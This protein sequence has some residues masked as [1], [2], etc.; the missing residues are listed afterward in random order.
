MENV[1]YEDVTALFNQASQDIKSGDMLF[2]PNF[3]LYDSMSAIEIYDA[4]MD[5]KANLKDVVGCHE[6]IKSNS[7]KA[8]QD[9]SV[10]ELIG[11]FDDLLGKEILWLSGQS[12]SHTIFTFSYLYEPQV[13]EGHKYLQPY[14][15][16]LYSGSNLCQDLIRHS[17]YL[18]EEDYIASSVGF[19]PTKEYEAIAQ[20]LV[21]IE[22][23]L[24]KQ[25]STQKKK[26]KTQQ[27]ENKAVHN[28]F[29][30]LHARIKLRRTLLVLYVNLKTKFNPKVRDQVQNTINSCFKT[31]EIVKQSLEHSENCE[32]YFSDSINKT[33]LAHIPPRQ[34]KTISKADAFKE[35]ENMLN[36]IQTILRLSDLQDFYEI[37][38]S[39]QTFSLTPK[40]VLVRAYLDVNVFQKDEYFGLI[41]IKNLALSAI[42]DFNLAKGRDIVSRDE[43]VKFV[44]KSVGILE[45]I[46]SNNLRNRTKQK[47]E[48]CK[49]YHSINVLAHDAYTLDGALF[50]KKDERNH[51]L[52]LW[53]MDIG[54]KFMV[55]QL[56]QGFELN[57]YADEEYCIIFYLLDNTISY[58]ERNFR[59][60]ISKYDNREFLAA[61]QT[62]D[63]TYDKKKKKLSPFQRRFFFESQYFK[64]IENYVSAM[65][66]LSYLIVYKEILKI[67]QDPEFLKNRY[68]M[69]LRIFDNVYFLRKTEFEDFAE[70]MKRLEEVDIETTIKECKALFESNVKLLNDIA[71]EESF[72][73]RTR[74]ELDKLKRICVMNSLALTTLDRNKDNLTNLKATF[75]NN[76]HPNYPILTLQKKA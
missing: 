61:W 76:E 52:F 22:R 23:E 34:V 51:V 21:E 49:I 32:K 63:S 20:D 74:T 38:R 10:K 44:E 19:P 42:E 53:V 14:I 73:A 3:S 11:L 39:L 60:V 71:S 6:M 12:L 17:P 58:L 16:A 5:L 35:L 56:I 13:F 24:E 54:L 70:S 27:E 43:V 28:E 75:S 55:K 31:L 65:L 68:Y 37:Q 47:R 26:K 7:I 45:D 67:P 25:L 41:S 62:K 9:L 8:P 69:R 1:T 46:L 4:K 59:S 36:N 57:L 72:D 18:R 30:A 64:V 15:Q 2:S 33:L 29:D 40:N 50:T 48:I 66:K